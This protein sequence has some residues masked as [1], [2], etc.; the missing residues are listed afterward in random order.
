MKRI[1]WVPQIS[2]CVSRVSDATG[3]E[4][5][6]LHVRVSHQL[7]RTQPLTTAKLMLFHHKTHNN[8]ERINKVDLPVAE[9]RNHKMSG[10]QQVAQELNVS[11]SPLFVI[12]DNK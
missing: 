1:V 10:T 5:I 3:E 4:N 11:T 8:V 7:M 2:V 12:S 9:Y 6:L